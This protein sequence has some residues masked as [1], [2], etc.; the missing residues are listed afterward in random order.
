MIYIINSVIPYN[1]FDE[2]DEQTIR[3]FVGRFEYQMHFF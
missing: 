2:F 3:P 1:T